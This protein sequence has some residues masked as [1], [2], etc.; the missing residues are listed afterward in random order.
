[1]IKKLLLIACLLTGLQ[2]VVHADDPQKVVSQV[3]KV[4]LFLNGAQVTRTSMVSIPAGNSTLVLKI[5]PLILMCK[6]YK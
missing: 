4:T 6:A 1:M 2:I 3:Q 5:S